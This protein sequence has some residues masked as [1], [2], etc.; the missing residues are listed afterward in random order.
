M[1]IAAIAWTIPSATELVAGV[2]EMDCNC[3]IETVTLAEAV[4]PAKLAVIVAVP[5]AT[6]VTAPLELTLA[7]DGSEETHA[8]PV[9]RFCVLPLA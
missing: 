4:R 5:P 9:V 3:V 8:A 7:T 2:I 1:P 6:P